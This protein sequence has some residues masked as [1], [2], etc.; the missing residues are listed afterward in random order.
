M[1]EYAIIIYIGS[2]SLS[3]NG[4]YNGNISS[5]VTSSMRDGSHFG[6]LSFVMS[7]ERTPETVEQK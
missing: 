4:L 7:K 2:S 3:G 5:S 6:L 1:R